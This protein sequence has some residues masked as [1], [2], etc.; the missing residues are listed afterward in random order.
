MSGVS[1]EEVLKETCRRDRS[2]DQM[3][4]VGFEAV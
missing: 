3:S 2:G 4:A 1:M